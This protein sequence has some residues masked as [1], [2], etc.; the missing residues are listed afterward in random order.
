MYMYIYEHIIHFYGSKYK[1]LRIYLHT[2]QKQVDTP[3]N[4]WSKFLES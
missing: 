3:I 1:N 2:D 4:Q